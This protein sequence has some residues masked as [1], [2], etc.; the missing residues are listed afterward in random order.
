MFLLVAGSCSTGPATKDTSGAT[1]YMLPDKTV[2]LQKD[3][4]WAHHKMGGSG[5]TLETDGCLV[6][7]A[8][9]VLGNLGF[10]MNPGVLNARLKKT[11]SFTSR[12]WLI[13][14]GIEKVTEGKAVARYYD[15]VSDEIILG[16]MR[17]GFYP[18]VRF[19]LPNGRTHWAMIV[20]RDGRGY[21]MR[22]PLHKSR[23]PLIF[24]G[25]AD[26]FKAVRCVGS[27]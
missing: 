10:K 2:Y 12:G 5:D 11:N 8:A 18:L 1:D 23:T 6:T 9:M 14:S 27:V 24:P 13:W 7:A 19:I 15:T 3:P 26:R 20:H 17:S 4:R 21:H 22:D 25:G 16:C